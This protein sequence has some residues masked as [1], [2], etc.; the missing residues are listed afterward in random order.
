VRVEVEPV[1]SQF[2]SS[3][4]VEELGREQ[5]VAP[6]EDLGRLAIEWPNDDSVD[7]FLALVREVRR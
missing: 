3:K 6:I 4:S 7:E 5:G 1:G 2:W